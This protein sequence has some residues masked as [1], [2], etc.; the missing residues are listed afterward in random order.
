MADDG[1][2]GDI[3]ALLPLFLSAFMSSVPRDV[4]TTTMVTIRSIFLFLM[5]AGLALVAG[6][7]DSPQA[8]GTGRMG[9]RPPAVVRMA[10]VERGSFDVAVRFVGRLRAESSAELYARVD[11]PIT[12]VLA[13][14]GDFVRRG[15]LLATIDPAEERQRVAQSSAALRIAEATLQQRRAGLEVAQ[16]NARRSESLFSQNLLSQ[17]D[18]DT[19]KAELTTAQSQ[20]ELSRAQI[21]QAR[22]NLAGAQLTL[23]Q[24]R[25]VAPFDGFIGTRHLDLGAHATTNRPVFSIVDLSTIRTTLAVPAQDAVRIR[26]GQEAS[27]VADVLPGRAFPGRVSRLSS[28]FDP[29]TNTV[30]AE[31]EVANPEGILKPGM[32]SSVT[33][34]YRTD[35]TALL[36]PVAAVQRNEQEEWVFVASKAPGGEGLVATRVPV[37]VLQSAD[38]AQTKVAVEPVQGT[39]A[40]GTQVIVLGQEN[41]ADGDIVYTGAPPAGAGGPAAKGKGKGGRR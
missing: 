21:E 2:F 5:A 17:S 23:D 35:A 34:A 12:A 32:Y 39:I 1:R 36:V 31:V 13:G 40:P 20:L 11:G 18:Y 22:S 38:A 3:S 6:C 14:T 7:G 4:K 33:I 9:G 16:A 37:R 24:T 8:A 30:E 26:P 15:Q 28:V 25:I 10:P 41:L 19:A 29:Q 27:V